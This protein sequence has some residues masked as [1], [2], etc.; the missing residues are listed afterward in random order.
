MAPHICL[1]LKDPSAFSLFL[2][3]YASGLFWCK[4][5]FYIYIFVNIWAAEMLLSSLIHNGARL[6]FPLWC[7]QHS[8]NVSIKHDPAAHTETTLDI[9]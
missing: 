6:Y 1:N 3:V 5:L 2:V 9:F 8:E 7:K 4:F